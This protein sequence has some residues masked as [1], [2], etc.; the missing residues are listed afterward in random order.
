MVN[1]QYG[2]CA[3]FLPFLSISVKKPRAT[4]G[5]MDTISEEE[6]EG[7]TRTLRKVRIFFKNH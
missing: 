3:I 4:K 2:H 1:Y 5:I 6:N 7:T